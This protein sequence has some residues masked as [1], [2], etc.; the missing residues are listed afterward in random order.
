MH[1]ISRKI[2]IHHKSYKN[3]KLFKKQN[4]SWG[5]DICMLKK[6]DKCICFRSRNICFV[7]S[8]CKY[9]LLFKEQPSIEVFAVAQK[10]AICK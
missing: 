10:S 9:Y 2:E 5:I 6:I 3:G 7:I 8:R 1:N 4:I